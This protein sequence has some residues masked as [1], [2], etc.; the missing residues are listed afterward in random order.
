[1]RQ[2][3]VYSIT[4]VSVCLTSILYT[5]MHSYSI[6]FYSFAVV[7]SLMVAQTERLTMADKQYHLTETVIEC[8]D[9]ISSTVQCQYSVRRNEV[10]A[11]SSIRQA[12]LDIRSQCV[13][14]L[15][16]RSPR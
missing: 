4:A 7:E 5:S 12:L 3:T 14:R 10:F 13:I 2:K 8:Y 9:N 15:D 16:R 11:F 1:M 6:I